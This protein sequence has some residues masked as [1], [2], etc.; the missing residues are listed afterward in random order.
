MLMKTTTKVIIVIFVA[1][2]VGSTTLAMVI[3]AQGL[4]TTKLETG[5]IALIRIEGTIQSSTGVFDGADPTEIL[6]LLR[7]STEDPN[8]KAVVLRI[9]SPGGQAAASQEIYREV[10][11]VRNAGK[12]VVA[13]IGDMAASGGYYVAS[14]ADKIISEPG[15][16][17]GSIGVISTIPQLTD[18]LEKLGIEYVIIKGGE[19]KDIGSPYREITPEEKELLQ[20][21]IDDVHDQFINDIAAGRGLDVEDVRKVADGRILTGRQAKELGL[22]DEFGNL[23]DAIDLA[24][25]MAGVESPTIT[26]FQRAPLL[27]ELLK[28]FSYEFGRAVIEN[29]LSKFETTQ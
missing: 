15:A 21:M 20:D 6:P 3:F 8:I 19:F 28:L 18:L 10:M 12:P 16:M 27:S 11:R 17:T 4:N 14:A 9:N 22:T 1:V 2:I 23:Y 13:S 25:E 5:N 29:L 26:E 24:A 7:T